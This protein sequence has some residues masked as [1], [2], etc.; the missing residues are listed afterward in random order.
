MSPVINYSHLNTNVQLLEAVT[1]I[2]QIKTI[3]KRIKH[4]IFSFYISVVF[5][6]HKNVS[7]HPSNLAEFF[8]DK[9]SLFF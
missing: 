2:N 4:V 5:T 7:L 9:A 3:G 8:Q 1:N 6:S